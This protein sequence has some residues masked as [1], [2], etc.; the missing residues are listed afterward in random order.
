M[1]IIVEWI[2]YNQFDNIKD[3]KRCFFHNIFAIWKDG[4]LK[5]N[6]YDYICERTWPNKTVALKYLHNSPIMNFYKKY[7]IT[8]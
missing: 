3:R 5:D 7:N 1:I 4:P 2:S 6:E 8:G